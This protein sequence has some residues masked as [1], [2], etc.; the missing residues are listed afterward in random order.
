MLISNQRKSSSKSWQN[1]FVVWLFEWYTKLW[2]RQ[3]ILASLWP[4]KL[5]RNS[6]AVCH[7]VRGRVTAMARVRMKFAAIVP[8]QYYDKSIY[9]PEA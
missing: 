2:K 9:L 1:V 4:G 5:A 3:A 6:A 8:S 7:A